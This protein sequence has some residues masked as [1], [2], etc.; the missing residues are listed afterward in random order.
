VTYFLRNLTPPA[1]S[2]EAF[3]AQFFPAVGW[4]NVL[5]NAIGTGLNGWL[6]SAAWRA[7]QGVPAARVDLARITG[8]MAAMPVAWLILVW[9]AFHS[10]AAWKTLPVDARGAMTGGTLIAFFVAFLPSL[11]LFLLFRRKSA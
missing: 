2:P 8:A 6:L 9:I 10:A 3:L 4:T 7:W 5:A 11:A 1:A